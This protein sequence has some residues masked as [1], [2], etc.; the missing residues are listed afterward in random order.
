MQGQPGSPHRPECRGHTYILRGGIRPYIRIVVGNETPAAI[1]PFGRFA[2]PYLQPLDEIEQRNMAFRQI[3]ALRRPIIHLCIDVDRV[4]AVPDG[5]HIL[6]P[7][8]LQIGGQ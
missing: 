3:A 5:Q 1:H 8:S 4:F 7:D 2:S 6:I